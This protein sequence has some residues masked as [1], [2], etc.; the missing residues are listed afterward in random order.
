[1][2][3]LLRG[4]VLWLIKIKISQEITS[5]HPTVLFTVDTDD[6]LFGHYAADFAGEV[7]FIWFYD[8]KVRKRAKFDISNTF[9]GTMELVQGNGT[10]RENGYVSTLNATVHNLIIS[11]KNQKHYD[12]AKYIRVYWFVNCEYI[13]MTDTLNYTTWYT[14][15]NG[16]YNVEALLMLSSEPFPE[17]TSTTQR[18]TTTTTTTTPSTTTS[19]TTTTTTTSTT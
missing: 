13:G 19:T 4:L 16:K 15:E 17:P 14:E 7:F 1:M 3:S 18:P 10:V 5:K 11:E 6:E 12:D 8:Q 9:K 2:N